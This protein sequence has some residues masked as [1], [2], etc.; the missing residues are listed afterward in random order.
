MKKLTKQYAGELGVTVEDRITGFRGIVTGH[1][2]Y[3]SGCNQGLVVPQATKD[4]SINSQWFDDQRLRIDLSVAPIVLENE[5]TPGCD[6]AAP[7]R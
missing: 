4:G 2:N 5:K 7:I 3:L 1:V 6:R